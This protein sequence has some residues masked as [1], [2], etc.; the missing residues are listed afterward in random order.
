MSRYRSLA[1]S[2]RITVTLPETLTLPLVS[3]LQ[4]AAAGTLTAV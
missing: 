2:R 4:V 1:A 3:T